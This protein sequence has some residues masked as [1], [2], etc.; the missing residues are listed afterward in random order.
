MNYFVI[1]GNG[2]RYGPASVD[3]LNSWATQ[4]RL[5]S[6]SLVVPEGSFDSIPISTVPG[7]KME[8]LAA[9]PMNAG[10][11]QNPSPYM[12]TSYVANNLVKAILVTL[13]CCMP[14]GIVSIVFAAQVDSMARSGDVAGA[15]AAAQ[16]ANIWA[17]WSLGLGLTGSILYGI[18]V[19]IAI[20]TGNGSSIR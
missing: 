19:A 5:N 6:Y 16:K 15:E 18:V 9:P 12:R 1:G 13:F 3:E 4:G 10:N 2:E 7:F 8:L 14:I 20:A 17:N 11:F